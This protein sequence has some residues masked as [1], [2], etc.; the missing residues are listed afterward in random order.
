MNCL[1][2]CLFLFISPHSL[3]MKSYYFHYNPIQV[4]LY[5]LCVSSCIC[6]FKFKFHI[7]NLLLDFLIEKHTSQSV[8]QHQRNIK[9][10]IKHRAYLWKINP[11]SPQANVSIAFFHQSHASFTAFTFFDSNFSSLSLTFLNSQ[12]YHLPSY[13]AST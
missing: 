10:S 3:L 9:P 2:F 6:S 7:S 4:M 13:L 12:N 8:S 5:S 11:R 1:K